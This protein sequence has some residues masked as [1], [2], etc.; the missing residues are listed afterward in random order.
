MVVI[1]GTQRFRDRV[2]GDASGSDAGCPPSWLGPWYATLLRWQ[3]PVAL[4]VNELTLLPVLVPMAPARTLLSRF[5]DA[6]AEVLEAH[7]VA[8]DLTLAA[9]ADMAT[10]RLK[11][12]ANRRVVGVISDMSAPIANSPH[13]STPSNRFPGAC[14]GEAGVAIGAVAHGLRDP[15]G[16]PRVC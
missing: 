4:F 12:T 3:A 11:P 5:P 14:E 7:G 10:I 9:V 13:S 1:H 16:G 6:V 8:A 2:P 15:I